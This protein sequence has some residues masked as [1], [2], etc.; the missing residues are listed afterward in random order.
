M[1]LN[2]GSSS[3]DVRVRPGT[4]QVA[5]AQHKPKT[6]AASHV[7]ILLRGAQV[8]AEMV[9]KGDISRCRQRQFHKVEVKRQWRDHPASLFN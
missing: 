2:A 3:A 9:V 6:G 8:T 5:N 7:S 4:L 1:L